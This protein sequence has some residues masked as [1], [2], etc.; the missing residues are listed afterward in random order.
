MRTLILLT[1][2]AGMAGCATSPL[3]RKQLVLVPEGQM[4]SLGSQAFSEMKA[5]QP[6]ERDPEVNAYV[7]CAALAVAA[8]AS[9]QGGASGWEIVVFRDK[10]AN[11]FALPGG[12]IGV[13]TGIL[14]VAATPG[15]LA[16]VLG[17]EVGHVIAHHGNERVSQGFV[18]QYGMAALSQALSGKGEGGNR[19][20]VV[21]LLGLGAQFGVLLPFSRKHESEADVIGLGLMAR[22]GFDPRESVEL[23]KNMA[24]AGGGQP[25]EFM[26]THP[27]HETR[28]SELQANMA[29][30]S[31]DFDRAFAAGRRPACRPPRG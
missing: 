24:K 13:H 15:Q 5:K 17:P 31:A 9:G 21:G 26:S 4:S 7:R 6:I 1:V 12:K 27:S 10:S 25:P 8:E 14:P 22:A 20:L 30:A 18:T 29:P 3:G 16:A 19:G 23:W 2:A 28:I 11:A